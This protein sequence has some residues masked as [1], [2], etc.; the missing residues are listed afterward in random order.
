MFFPCEQA[1]TTG[2]S[3][4]A[5][6]P[7]KNQGKR[8]LLR[9][10]FLRAEHLT[11]VP[12]SYAEEILISGEGLEEELRSRQEDLFGILNGVDYEVWNLET[13]RH[14]WANYSA[15]DGGGK[16]ENKERLLDELGLDAEADT[17][18]VGSVRKRV[19]RSV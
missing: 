10:G 19:P 15:S 11:T 1:G 18:L 14:L 5:L 7:F 3:G 12:P 16:E 4:E 17:P 13:D 8:N 6:A 2:L 9:G